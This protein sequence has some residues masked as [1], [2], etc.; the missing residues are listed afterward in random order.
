[1]GPEVVL[2]RGPV[3]Q[4]VLQSPTGEKDA[5]PA[6]TVVSGVSL[7]LNTVANAKYLQDTSKQQQTDEMWSA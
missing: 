3:H 4:L 6:G 5:F 2:G 1:M 7:L